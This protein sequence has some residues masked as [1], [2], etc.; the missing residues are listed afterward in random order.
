[1]A[2]AAERDELPVVLITGA[3]GNLGGSI[4]AALSDAYRIVGLDTDAGDGDFPIY[5]ADLTSAESIDAALEKVRA[6]HG[7]RLASVIHL[8]A[9]FDFTGEEH[10]L[11]EKLNVEGTRLL[12]RA[13]QRFEVEQFVYASTMLVH[14]PCQPGQRIDEDWPI[15]PR[16]AYPRSKA[17]AE[18]AA[19]EEKGHIPLLILR[20]AGVYDEETMVPT[21]AQQ[22][23]R[24]YE[25]DFQSYFYS[26]DTDVGQSM[27]HREDMVDAF[28]RAVD[29]RRELPRECALLIG[30]PGAVGYDALQDEIG[31]LIHGREDWPTLRLPKAVAAAG[32]WAQEKLE[33][34]IPDSI[35]KGEEPFVKPFM[36][37]MADDHYALDVSR[38]RDL[39]GWV[40]GHRLKTELPAMI[41]NLKRDPLNWYRANGVTPPEWLEQAAEIGFHPGELR[42]R[43]VRQLREEHRAWR[44]AHFLNIALGTWLLTQPPLIGVENPWLARIE[45][46]LGAALVVFATLSLSW[47]MQWARWICA[48]IGMVM[49]AVPFVFWTQVAADYLSNTLVGMLVFGLAFASKP[50]PA[51]SPIAALSGP[52]C[53]PGWS[54]NPSTWSQRLPII[55]L[56]FIGL[57]VSRYLAA[58]QL[59]Y[60]PD[61]WDPFFAGS[62]ADPQNG[63][64]E[65]IT[66]HV[67][68]AFPVS[69][70]ALGG[71]VYALEIVT[72]AIGSTARWRTMPWLVILFGILI[73]PLGIVSISFIIIQPIIIGTW[74]II[75]LIGAAAILIQIPYSLDELLASLQF[76]RR[77]ARAGRNWIGVLFGGDTDEG[78]GEGEGGADEFDAQPREVVREMV[79]GGVNLP[80]NLGIAAALGLWLLFTRATLGAE[81][82][83][84]DADHLIGSLVLTVV[85]VAAAEVAR[86]VR[87]LLIPLGLALAAMPF[88]VGASGTQT[89][90]G[91]AVGLLIAALSLR[92]GTVRARYGSWSR[93][94]P[95]SEP[96]P[97]GTA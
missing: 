96:A 14:A 66:S 41:A 44:W 93:I 97:S 75:A 11:Y 81:G 56:A 65:I 37:R 7:S 68:E 27:L 8:A 13:L 15:G 3:A 46:L 18:A 94:V 47:R 9:F 42:S 70:A 95:P 31:Y 86:P 49:M 72:G 59:G 43:H 38:A 6:N 28:R 26:G 34:V 80:W 50:D 79:L 67:S 87:L 30:E 45:L 69:D 22:I 33:P 63:T 25:R 55:L 35:D 16:W 52:K 5:E 76:I 53:P 57:Y 48:G 77:R 73:A 74:S 71:Y 2:S 85:S 54:Y 1:M 83:M 61:V 64:E 12:L 58:Y 10:P 92:R 84:A 17:A 24:I 19:R 21:L 29:R 40:P 62:P 89:I 4:A 82:A 88:L 91:V 90:H 23:A 36:V 20:L 60:I 32:A 51:V 78:P 39:L